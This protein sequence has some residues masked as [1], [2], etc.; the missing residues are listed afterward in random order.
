MANPGKG[1]QSIAMADHFE[2]SEDGVAYLSVLANDRGPTNSGKLLIVGLNGPVGYE[3]LITIADDGK[4]LIFQDVNGYFNN[5]NAG[6]DRTLQFSYTVQVSN[7]TYS[8]GQVTLTVNGVNDIVISPDPSLDI[9]A[10]AIEAEIAV[11]LGDGHGEFTTT[12]PD[13]TVESGAVNVVL[14]DLDGDGDLDIA[15]ANHSSDN[16]SIRLNNGSGGFPSMVN[17]PVGDA[18]AGIALGDVDGDG[19]LDIL[20]ANSGDST[21]SVLLGNGSG[22][23]A[24]ATSII[25]APNSAPVSIA[26]GDLNND[27]KLDFVTANSFTHDVSI[28]LGN[29][30]GGFT[31]TT[32]GSRGTGPSA[33]AIGNIAG[34]S[35]LDLVVTNFVDG[36]VAILQG[37]GAGGFTAGPS[38][39]AGGQ[40]T[41]VAIGDLNGDG[42]LDFVTSNLIAEGFNFGSISV[43]LN[44]G[45]GTFAETEHMVSTGQAF[46][47]SVALGDLDGDGFVDIVA[48]DSIGTSVYVLFG[49]GDGT[50]DAAVKRSVGMQSQSV[51]LGDLDGGAGS[52]TA[53]GLPNLGPHVVDPAGLIA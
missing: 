29:G 49:N 43:R 8:T 36:V 42:K 16:V 41:D 15:A 3:G 28:G 45:D 21:V 48:A 23:F 47:R 30:A 35:N 40:P 18:P 27:G 37:N 9:V 25:L 31:V 1:N 13:V 11:A 51:A 32:V 2:V 6:Q 39:Y 34:D 14:G 20:T 4:S 10:G 24:A 44:N 53:A 33:V 17:I 7:G 38:V 52:V 46:L 26:L 22:G 50:F 19:D 12:K 5:L